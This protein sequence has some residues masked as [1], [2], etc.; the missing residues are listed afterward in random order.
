MRNTGIT[1]ALIAGLMIFGCGD[2]KKT[3]KPKVDKPEAA[4]PK[5]EKPEVEKPKAE[6]PKTPGPEVAQCDKILSKSWTAI[7]PALKMLKIA[8]PASLEEGYK[9]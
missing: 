2:K 7:Q 8:D 1:I 4:E 3:E 6:A 9:K 5:A